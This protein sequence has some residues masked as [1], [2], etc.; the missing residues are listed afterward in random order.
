[1]ACPTCDH[2][3][4][5]LTPGNWHCP[6]CGTVVGRSLAEPIVPQLVPQADSLAWYAIHECDEASEPM[7]AA[8]AVLDCTQKPDG[9][10]S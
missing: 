3:M 5:A 1:M 10:P 6:R 4:A 9:R 8:E 2:T 7:T